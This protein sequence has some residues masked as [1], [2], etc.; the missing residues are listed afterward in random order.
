M[1]VCEQHEL[2]ELSS[3]KVDLTTELTDANM[4]IHVSDKIFVY[5]YYYLLLLLFIFYYFCLLLLLF[6]L[7]LLCLEMAIYLAQC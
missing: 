7:Y 5:Y 1:I 3:V 4:Q 6:C 2:T